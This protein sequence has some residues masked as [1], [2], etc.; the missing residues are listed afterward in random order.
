MEIAQAAAALFA[1]H[2]TENVTAEAIAAEAGVSPRTF[3]R[4][5]RTKEDAVA[6]VL[7]VGA[8]TWQQVVARSPRGDVSAGIAR[9]IAEVLTPA[10][11]D[12]EVTGLGQTRELLNAMPGDPALR[13]VW[14][15][16]ND[17]SEWRL[18]R[19]IADLLDIPPHDL[20]ARLLAAAATAAIRIGLEGWAASPTAAAYDD[21]V[22]GPA[23]VAGRAFAQLVDG[24][25]LPGANRS[26]EES[27]TR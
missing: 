21:P 23:A 6:P 24:I 9:A 13:A 14:L 25:A 5:F 26:A 7:E 22:S 18:G 15:S 19:I 20:A 2:G 17:D 4:Y 3:Y 1:A 10:A 11:G 12:A 16:V 27:A 8:D